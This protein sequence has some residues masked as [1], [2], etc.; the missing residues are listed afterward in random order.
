MIDKRVQRCDNNSC[1]VSSFFFFFLINVTHF[2]QHYIWSLVVL[3]THK[4]FMI[5][6]F[7]GRYQFFLINFYEKNKYQYHLLLFFPHY[8]ED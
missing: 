8:S 5:N 1:Q 7:T 3:S 4:Y 2:P 6:F